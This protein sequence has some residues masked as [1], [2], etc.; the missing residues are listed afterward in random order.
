MKYHFLIM[1]LNEE[2][3]LMKTYKELIYVIRKT[4]TK[5]Y[6]IYI[7]DDGSTD[8]TFKID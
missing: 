4:N 1:A 6:K 8:N 2:K 3:K 7:V 5:N